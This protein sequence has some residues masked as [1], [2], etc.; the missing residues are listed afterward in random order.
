MYRWIWAQRGTVRT[1]TQWLEFSFF[2]KHPYLLIEEWLVSEL[3]WLQTLRE[4]WAELLSMQVKGRL[5][6]TPPQTLQT[7]CR[8]AGGRLEWRTTGLIMLPAEMH[9]ASPD[10]AGGFV[11]M[12]LLDEKSR[13]VQ[14]MRHKGKCDKNRTDSIRKAFSVLSCLV[15][16]TLLMFHWLN[17][18]CCWL[19]CFC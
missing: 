10:S 1:S 9:K 18:F 12:W 14:N 11:K 4:V 8:G 3:T 6:Q 7:V 19:K 16:F 17:L 2:L 13:N 15:V 5:Q